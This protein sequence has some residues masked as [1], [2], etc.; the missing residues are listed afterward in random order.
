MILLFFKWLISEGVSRHK[1]E[2][3]TGFSAKMSSGLLLQGCDVLLVV[4][5]VVVRL[6]EALM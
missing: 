5:V 3:R 4:S 1:P 2:R 6:C